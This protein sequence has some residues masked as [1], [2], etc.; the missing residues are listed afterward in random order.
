MELF[1]RL[2]IDAGLVIFLMLSTIIG[3]IIVSII[4]MG[5][6]GL[7]IRLESLAFSLMGFSLFLIGVPSFS[8]LIATS[9]FC[10]NIAYNINHE[11]NYLDIIFILISCFIYIFIIMRGLEI[12]EDLESLENSELT[13]EKQ[14][15]TNVGFDLGLF[16]NRISLIVDAYQRKGFDLIGRIKTSGVGGELFKDAN[17]ADMKSRG[18]DIGLTATVVNYKDFQWKTNFQVI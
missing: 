17:Y 3:N 13:W 6:L 5:I 15:E 14:Y 12:S 7:P 4:W 10:G 9:Y 11:F 8:P 2:A 18:I 1:Y 16:N